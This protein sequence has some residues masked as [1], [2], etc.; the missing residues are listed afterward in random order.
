VNAGILGDLDRFLE[1]AKFGDLVLICG[2]GAPETDG[3][4]SSSGF[5][6]PGDRASS[7]CGS[8]QIS[9]EG[10]RRKIENGVN[11]LLELSA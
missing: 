4:G 10:L 11:R 9:A 1:E 6:L 2:A 7:D 5:R 3:C 8:E